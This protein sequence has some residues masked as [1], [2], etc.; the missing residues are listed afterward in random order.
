MEPRQTCG[1]G[2]TY[3][4]HQVESRIQ[5]CLHKSEE[6]KSWKR[7]QRIQV[8]QSKNKLLLTI[9]IHLANSQSRSIVIMISVQTCSCILIFKILANHSLNWYHIHF[10]WTVW[11][12]W[13]DHLVDLRGRPLSRPGSDH[14]IHTCCL[15]VPTFQNQVKQNRYSVPARIVGWPSGS[16]I[17]CLV[18]DC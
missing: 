18:I 17:P 1:W 6:Q 8:C 12:G 14:Y 10:G 16:L 13:V 7:T 11:Q 5:R 4:M 9:L 15:S 3:A 2:E